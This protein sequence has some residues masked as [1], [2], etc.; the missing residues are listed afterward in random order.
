MN[1][2][3][4]YNTESKDRW[5]SIPLG[6]GKIGAL[7]QATSN[8]DLIYLNEDTLW[9]GDVFDWQNKTAINHLQ[10]TRDLIDA[11]KYKKAQKESDEMLGVF[12]Q[13]YMP[14]ARLHIDYKNIDICTDFI[15][16]LDMEKAIC[17]TN[18]FTNNAEIK[19]EYF[20]S[21]EYNALLIKIKSEKAISADFLLESLLKF[22]TENTNNGLILFGK[23]P[24][25]V[26]C[27]NGD[28]KNNRYKENVVY[29]ENK[30]IHFC[31]KLNIQTDGEI[32]NNESGECSVLNAKE[33]VVF[34]SSA[35]NF[36]DY[37]TPI[38]KSDIDY[39]SICK[40]AIDR[41]VLDGYEKIKTV[42]T[43]DFSSFFNRCGI[44]LGDIPIGIFTPDMFGKNIKPQSAALY[45]AYGRYLMIS[46]SRKG[47]EPANLQGIWST[48]LIPMWAANYT[49]NCNVQINYWLAEIANLSECHLPL[50]EM[51]KELVD[52]GRKTATYNYNCRGWLAHHNS[53][54][55][56]ITTAMDGNSLWAIWKMGGAWLCCD[57]FEHYLFTEDKQF[58][59]EIYPVMKECALFF[60]DFLTE[61]NEGNLVVT[62]SVSFENSY[63]TWRGKFYITNDALEDKLIITEL[64]NNTRKAAHIL[65]LDDDYCEVLKEKL[66]KLSP[67]KIDKKT[68]Q[69]VEWHKYFEPVNPA[70]LAPLWGIMPGTS[71]DEAKNPELY[72]A[73]KKL[74]YTRKP[75]VNDNC[76]SWMGAWPTNLAA[77]F[78]DGETAWFIIKKHLSEEIEENLAC[79]FMTGW[80]CDGNFGVAAGIVEM[81]I[82]S[83]RDYIE[84]LPA[85]PQE[86]KNGY[87]HGLCARGG[88]ELDFK[89]KDGKLTELLIFSKLG[90]KCN[91]MINGSKKM[92]IDT[93]KN[94]KY[95]IKL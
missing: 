81:L 59:S 23:A 16:T 10:K 78:K 55:W 19:R 86:W 40:K 67:A 66:N 64:F 94:K 63:K 26:N 6:N 68:G 51:T 3:L 1:N 37:K 48:E 90:N 72:N 31:V 76:G 57:M 9:S 85:L 28:G 30:G 88:F 41:A 15:R 47:T 45:F 7:V 77:R 2:S 93:Q 65:N 20:V 29:E 22:K 44:D 5:S 49:L 58:L 61:N 71:M 91:I 21:H 8:S 89:W 75:W 38:E 73:C 82:Q 74:F 18:F 27:Y 80:E 52:D 42:H 43:K 56:R 95:S 54:L 24:Y 46:S 32:M 62:P 14:M 50:I 35:N 17:N 83:H 25:F 79:N 84:I 69:I 87:V 12:G 4:K 34:V 36:K 70:Q 33:I 53:D 92:C 11:G 60:V 39:F 13:A